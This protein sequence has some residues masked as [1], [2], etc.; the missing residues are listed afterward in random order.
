[1]GARE[2]LAAR[3]A[4]IEDLER[5]AGLE[6]A[7]VEAKES[8]DEDAIREASEALR[9]VRFN[10]RKDRRDAAVEAPPVAA[11]AGVEDPR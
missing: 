6:E 7:L 11:K 3:R 8:G 9:E 4:E 10:A 2:D 1:M 5:V